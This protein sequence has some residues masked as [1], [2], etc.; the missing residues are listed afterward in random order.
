M[1]TRRQLIKVA[2]R[3]LAASPAV[4]L[5]GPW[6]AAAPA[7]PAVLQRLREQGA[8]TAI[9]RPYLA[10]FPQENALHPLLTAL[11]QKTS[12]GPDALDGLPS[13]R[14]RRFVREQ[15]ERDFAAGDVV[16]LDGWIVARSEARLCALA[17]LA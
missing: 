9:G 6:G 17:T 1:P 4:G 5:A 16:I 7:G 12:V 15:R 2:A 8:A 11:L 14:L 13:D 3:L 10:R